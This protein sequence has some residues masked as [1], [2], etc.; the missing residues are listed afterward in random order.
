MRA[1]EWFSRRK[2]RELP[3]AGAAP[4]DTE[5]ALNALRVAMRTVVPDGPDGEGLGRL[6]AY[7][8]CARAEKLDARAYA[9]SVEA[10]P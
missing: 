5:E 7:C 9:H 1:A 3:M 10:R 8:D 4:R 6:V 2:A